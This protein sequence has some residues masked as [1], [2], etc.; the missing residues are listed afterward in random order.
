MKKYCIQVKNL[1]AADFP[2]CVRPFF[3]N[4]ISVGDVNIGVKLS[5]VA[6]VCLC[7]LSPRL[8]VKYHYDFGLSMLLLNA[9]CIGPSGKGKRII[10]FI[11]NMLMKYFYEADKVERE[12]Y[13]R[14]KS[15]NKR[16]A[17]N[18]KGEEEPAV[19]IRCLQKFTLPIITKYAD[20][21]NRKYG[22]ILPFFLFAPEL[23]SFIENRRGSADFKGMARTAYDLGEA[24]RRDTLY[25]GGHNA[26]VDINWLSIICGQETVLP[27]LIDKEGITA[28]DPSRNIL[29][30][31][32]EGI[33]DPAPTLK[34]FTEGQKQVID[35]TIRRL[36]S[37]TFSEDDQLMPTHE[38]DMSWLDK[39]VVSWCDRQ[40]EIITKSG[41]R[42]H[43]SFYA[44]ASTSAFRLATELYYLFGEDKAKQRNVRRCYYYFAQFILDGLMAQWGQQ[45][46]AAMP[47]DNEVTI[48]RPSLYDAL[49]KRFTRKELAEKITELNI[50]SAPRK[51]IYKWMTERKWIFEVEGQADTYE[52]IYE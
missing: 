28:G 31:I 39:D 4:A 6:I 49:G 44:R 7:A 2:T 52:K 1:T 41:S 13:S 45:Y 38:V 15:E 32:G 8:R 18:K 34:P 24:Y 43:D 29:I 40:R 47:K 30:K 21:I 5:I 23:G 25:D 10:G 48:A 50:N 12:I 20:L 33:G 42:A 35:D 36:W 22:D 11:V 9:L 26:A 19:A 37:E 17:N 51:F 46:E 16:R 27:K 14:W 3:V